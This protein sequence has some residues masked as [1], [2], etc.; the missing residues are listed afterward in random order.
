MSQFS[1]LI[2]PNDAFKHAFSSSLTTKNVRYFKL[3]IE[4][5][6]IVEVGRAAPTSSV[7]DDYKT[8]QKEFKGNF[9]IC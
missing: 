8:L 7:I 2:F 9:F 1:T 3:S 4:N 6:Q 5:E